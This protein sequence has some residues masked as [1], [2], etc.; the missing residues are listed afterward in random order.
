[1][2][3]RLC[4][5]QDLSRLMQLIGSHRGNLTAE[6]ENPSNSGIVPQY[7]KTWA[8][9]SLG[10]TLAVDRVAS[11]QPDGHLSS[12]VSRSADPRYAS[13]FLTRNPPAIS[14]RCSTSNGKNPAEHP[15]QGCRPMV[16]VGLPRLKSAR[17]LTPLLDLQLHESS[18]ARADRSPDAQPLTYAAVED[19]MK[20]RRMAGSITPQRSRRHRDE[21]DFRRRDP[22]AS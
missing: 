2:Q 5:W 15:L 13:G 4:R 11:G 6:G 22:D 12:C 3:L 7:P 17:H 8:P 20:A 9:F 19:S 21:L 14:P 16:C 18:L 1:M 10:R